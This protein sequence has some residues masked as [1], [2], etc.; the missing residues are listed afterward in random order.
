V[1]DIATLR[2]DLERW[3]TAS[4]VDTVQDIASS[5]NRDITFIRTPVEAQAEEV[6]QRKDVT[7]EF[8]R[9]IMTGVSHAAPGGKQK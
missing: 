3:I 6:R 1:K 2:L 8:I 5:Q 4:V 9:Y 7:Q